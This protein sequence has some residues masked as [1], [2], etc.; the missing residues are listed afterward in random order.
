[1][2]YSTGTSPQA[3][4]LGD[5]N[6]DGRIDLAVADYASNSVSV[7]MQSPTVSLSPSSL[8]FGIQNI[9]TTSVAQTVALTNT[10]SANLLVNSVGTSG[11]FAQTNTCGPTIAAGSSCSISVTFTP[12][13]TGT[14]AGTLAITDNSPGS[15]E[16][17]SLSGIGGTAIGSVHPT[18]LVFGGQLVGSTSAAKSV[19]LSNTGNAQMTVSSIQIN[20][21]FQIA[22]NFCGHGVRPATH[23]N[24]AVTFSPTGTG[25]RGGTL[26]FNDDAT[27]TPQL[28]ALGG[29]G[30]SPTTTTVQSSLSP[31][32]YGQAVTLTA[33]VTSSGGTPTG[34]V[35][36]N[37]GTTILGTATLSSGVAK[38]TKSTLPAGRDSITATYNGDTL[39]ATSTS[40]VLSQVVNPAKTTTI[41]K[42]SL[43]PSALGQAVKFTATVTSPTA[44]VTGSVTFTAGATTLGTVPL[45]SGTASITTSKLPHGSTVV[46][47]TFSGGSNFVGSSASLTQI[48]N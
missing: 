29:T 42:T 28:V 8:A 36:F 3:I 7:L 26:T 11:D 20:G 21:D 35:T 25:A 2:N 39:F 6:G 48:V 32:T 13:A 41:I 43:N 1:M 4:T 37:N 24:V 34:T 9:H 27:N 33:T 45:T 38:L 44:H 16:T 19:A 40:A 46:K 12:T 15:P 31:S 30:M 5:F 17:V 47:A 10:G 22:S 23:C 14:R 18:A